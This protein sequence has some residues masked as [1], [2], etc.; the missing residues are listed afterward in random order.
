[1][2][3]FFI[4]ELD[5]ILKQARSSGQIIYHYTSL[6]L[7]KR[8]NACVLM[9]CYAIV[10]LKLTSDQVWSKFKLV[11]PKFI[12]Y[13][14]ASFGPCHYKCKIIHVLRGI[15]YACLIGWYSFQRFNLNEY[16]YYE[17]FENGD[18]NWIIPGKLLAFSTPRNEQYDQ[19]GYRNMTPMDYVPIFK[20]FNVGTVVRLNNKCYDETC[21]IENNF[22]H[23]ELYFPDGSVPSERIVQKFIDL[24]ESEEKAIAVHCK[25]GLGRTGTLIALYAMKHYHFPA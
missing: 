3:H 24:C 2:V 6:D 8:N 22:K 18:L 17:N 7:A 12:P 19:E 16:L 23:H 11:R 14:D 15:E 10:V 25:A 20:A 4:S 21:F 13:R 1:M 9:A 5:K